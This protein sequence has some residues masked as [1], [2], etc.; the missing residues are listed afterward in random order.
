MH[1]H[2]CVYV[3]VHINLYTKKYVHCIYELAILTCQIFIGRNLNKWKGN[4]DICS[5]SSVK[6]MFAHY[7]YR[8]SLFQILKL[9]TIIMKRFVWQPKLLTVWINFKKKRNISIFKNLFCIIIFFKFDIK[10]GCWRLIHVLQWRW[11]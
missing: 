4:N 5:T 6:Q 3:F 11:W 8:H 1:M 9:G 2:I 7:F 10:T